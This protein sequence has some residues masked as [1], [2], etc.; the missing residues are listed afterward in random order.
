MKNLNYFMEEKQINV[1][2]SSEIVFFRIEWDDLIPKKYYRKINRNSFRSI[3]WYNKHSVQTKNS[4]N[5]T[6]R[7]SCQEEK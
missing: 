3:H 4:S 7:N 2:N 1:R 5:G 6:T